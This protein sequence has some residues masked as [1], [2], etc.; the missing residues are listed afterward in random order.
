MRRQ[1][2][3]QALLLRAF[4]RSGDGAM[5]DVPEHCVAPAANIAQAAEVPR[6]MLTT[7]PGSIPT[8]TLTPVG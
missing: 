5:A 2:K 8:V 6:K 4:R 1:R 3:S 7:D